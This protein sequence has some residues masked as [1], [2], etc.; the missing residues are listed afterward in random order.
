MTVETLPY[1]IIDARYAGTCKRCHGPIRV[2]QLIRYYFEDRHAEHAL[3]GEC[4]GPVATVEA[5]APME[6]ATHDGY[7]TVVLEDEN[8]HYTFRLQTQDDDADFAPG[9]QIMSFLGADAEYIK[10]A[11]VTGGRVYPWRRF[12]DGYGRLLMA[13]QYL[14]HGRNYEA[15]GKMYA[16][17]SG[18]CWRCNTMLTDPLSIELGIGP[19]CRNKI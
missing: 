15:A 10:F 3:A 9:Q 13:A 14:V 8:K 12:R 7:F 1:K 4:S 11:F 2:V 6:L 18:H 16:M 19:T 17:D 5:E